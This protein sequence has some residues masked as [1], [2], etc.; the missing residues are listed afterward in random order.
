MI[1]CRSVLLCVHLFWV[2]TKAQVMLSGATSRRPIW[3]FPPRQGLRAELETET[4]ISELL[5]PFSPALHP[6]PSG[7]HSPFC[8]KG[9]THGRKEM[10]THTH[11]GWWWPC[12]S[13]QEEQNR[14]AILQVVRPRVC[15]IDVSSLFHLLQ[16]AAHMIT[17]NLSERRGEKWLLI[18][19]H[20]PSYLPEDLHAAIPAAFHLLREQ[21]R[22]MDVT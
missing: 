14:S 22:S 6:P 21:H 20:P 3:H 13:C 19:Y 7:S 12:F 16:T 4:S 1:E 11:L 18:E 5:S 10:N 8:C 15:A 17:L 2:T 9:A